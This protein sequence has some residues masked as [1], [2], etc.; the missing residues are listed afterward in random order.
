ME[1]VEASKTFYFESGMNAQKVAHRLG[2]HTEVTFKTHST[3][4][5]IDENEPL[6]QT[7]QAVLAERGAPLQLR[8][9]FIGSDTSGFRPE[10]KAFTISTGVVKEHSVDEYVSIAPLE[11]LVKDTLMLLERLR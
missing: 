3:G 6:L 11:Q 4:Y 7:Y 2:G 9:T 10:I 1:G 5:S 8:P